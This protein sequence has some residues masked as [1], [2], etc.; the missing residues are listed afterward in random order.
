M[1]IKRVKATRQIGFGSV[2]TP[3]GVSHN[4]M[5][6]YSGTRIVGGHNSSVVFPCKDSVCDTHTGSSSPLYK[7]IR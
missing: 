4:K 2:A 6:V 1:V 5:P 3:K 7:D